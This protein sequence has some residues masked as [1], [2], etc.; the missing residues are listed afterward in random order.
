MEQIRAVGREKLLRFGTVGQRQELP[1]VKTESHLQEKT[2]GKGE[3]QIPK[4]IDDTLDEDVLAF[5]Q[6][7]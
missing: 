5:L 1:T 7:G 2:G 4:N 3:M 6:N